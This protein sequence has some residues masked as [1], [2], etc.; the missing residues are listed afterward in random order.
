MSK[1]KKQT[2]GIIVHLQLGTGNTT[3][4]GELL[5][6]NTS[7]GQTKRKP[8]YTVSKR[9]VNC[10][11]IALGAMWQPTPSYQG[12]LLFAI[13]L[14]WRDAA[15]R[16]P[17]CQGRSCC[18][19]TMSSTQDNSSHKHHHHGEPFALPT[20]WDLYGSTKSNAGNLFQR[21]RPR[22]LWLGL[23]LIVAIIAQII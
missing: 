1:P 21:G 10:H 19:T 18:T 8:P 22:A 13:A 5:V 2:K 15:R 3:I 9:G 20:V 7:P 17:L 12:E 16:P 4:R 14:H 23:L 11:D 6:A